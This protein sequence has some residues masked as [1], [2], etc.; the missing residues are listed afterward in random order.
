LKEVSQIVSNKDHRRKVGLDIGTFR[1]FKGNTHWNMFVYIEL[2]ELIAKRLNE[3]MKTIFIQNA[4]GI[5]STSTYLSSINQQLQKAEFNLSKATT[6]SG[7]N[8]IK[9]VKSETANIGKIVQELGKV[10]NS[11]DTKIKGIHSK[12][13]ETTSDTKEAIIEHLETVFRD[14]NERNEATQSVITNDIKE[15]KDYSTKKIEDVFSQNQELGKSNSESFTKLTEGV[16]GVQSGVDEVKERIS[17]FQE[18]NSNILDDLQGAI[19]NEF[20]EG[21]GALMKQNLDESK[22]SKTFLN[23]QK[24]EI[25]KQIDE[26]VENFSSILEATNEHMDKVNENVNSAVS[27]SE[28]ELKKELNKEIADMRSILSTI[29]SDIELMKSVLTKVDSKIH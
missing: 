28:K 27:H 22:S 6:L 12:I 23:E 25:I 24:K 16:S 29:R 8:I 19:V 4:Q 17:N 3:D 2:A 9:V 26:S 1:E 14:L 15:L 10:Q 7:N 21:V 20:Q 11:M 18:A 5:N 13:L